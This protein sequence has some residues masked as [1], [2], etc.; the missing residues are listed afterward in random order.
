MWVLR[1][2]SRFEASK[3]S[4]PI[5]NSQGVRLL[6]ERAVWAFERRTLYDF[7]MVA[8]GDR[9]KRGPRREYC[10]FWI[11]RSPARI[12]IGYIV[13][14]KPAGMLEFLF[15]DP[16]QHPFVRVIQSDRQLIQGFPNT[17]RHAPTK[18]V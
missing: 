3:K 10:L 18:R 6:T 4:E 9:G 14:A 17:Q 12:E 15:G 11:F 8:I 7:R 2:Y 1:L 13:R 16:L 5:V